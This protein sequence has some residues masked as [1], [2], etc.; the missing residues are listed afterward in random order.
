MSK[1]IDEI[2]DELLTLPVEARAQIAHKLI[3]CLEGED[4]AEIESSWIKEAKRRTQELKDGK[5]RGVLAKDAIRIA[6][7]SQR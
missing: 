7:E 5:V 4:I 6:R 3:L 1:S 2:S